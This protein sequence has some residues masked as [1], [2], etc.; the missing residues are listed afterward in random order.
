MAGRELGKLAKN[1]SHCKL[2]AGIS[3]SLDAKPCKSGTPRAGA[4][5]R[6]S[7][8]GGCAGGV[9]GGASAFPA[10][11]P[12]PRSSRRLGRLPHLSRARKKKGTPKAAPASPARSSP[13]PPCPE[14]LSGRQPKPTAAATRTPSRTP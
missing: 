1:Y 10:P 2:T 13:S 11:L 4:R 9:G 14:P 6:R 8:E 3:K 12:R 5:L 7:S